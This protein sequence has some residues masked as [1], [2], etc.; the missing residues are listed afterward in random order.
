[1]T[2]FN[3]NKSM[4][5]PKKANN[6]FYLTKESRRKKKNLLLRHALFVFQSIPTRHPPPS[7]F[8]LQHFFPL[9]YEGV[10]SPALAKR[11]LGVH[12]Q[13]PSSHFYAT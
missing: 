10:C 2:V 4:R 12:S 5:L 1:M 8:P 3:I 9:F 6:T 13:V 7:I 11:G